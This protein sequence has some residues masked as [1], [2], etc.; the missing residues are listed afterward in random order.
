M[1]AKLLKNPIEHDDLAKRVE[2]FF[3]ND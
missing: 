1:T 2:H 3:I